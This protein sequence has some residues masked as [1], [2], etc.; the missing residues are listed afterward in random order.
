MQTAAG[1]LIQSTQLGGTR[2]RHVA[3][4][5][6]C[7]TLRQQPWRQEFC[8]VVSKVLLPAAALLLTLMLQQ[9]KTVARALSQ[10]WR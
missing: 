10:A 8:K 3:V 1:M 5:F 6:V 7:A 4:L 2:R 9:K